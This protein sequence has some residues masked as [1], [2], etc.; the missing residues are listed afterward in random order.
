MVVAW[1]LRYRLLMLGIGAAFVLFGATQLSNLPV[2]TVPEFAPTYVEVQTEALGLSADEVEQLITVPL[3][4]DLL[5]GV[6]FLDE[7]HSQSVAGL[8]SIVMLFEPGTD[9]FRARQVVSERLTQAHAL[10]NVSKPPTMIQPLSS[11][12]RLMMI[13]LASKDVSMID[14]SVLAQWTVRPRLMSVPG[15]ANVTIWGMRDRQLQVVVDPAKLEKQG[16]TLEKVIETTGNSLWV[17]PLTFLDASTPGTGGFIDTP[18]QRLGVHHIFPVRTPADLASIV[19]RPDDTGG[20]VV[21]LG[22]LATVIE[23]HQPLIGDAVVGDGA[24]LMLV[25]E[26]FPAADTVEVT[27]NV[28]K[29]MAALAPGLTG[30]TIDTTIF[31]PATFIEEASSNVSL[32]LLAGLLLAAIALFIFLRGWRPAVIVLVSI[33]MTM[34]AAAVVLYV[35]GATANAMALAGVMIAALVVIDDTIVGVQAIDGRLRAPRQSDTGRSARSIVI[36]AVAEIRGSAAY[37]WLIVGLA[38]VPL[39]LLSGVAGSF[40]PPM[41]TAYVIASLVGIAVALTLTPALASLLLSK[42]QRPQRVIAVTRRLAG[43]YR[44]ALAAGLPRSRAIFAAAAVVT[45][46][47]VALAGLTVAGQRDGGFAPQFKERDL[48]IAVRAAPGTSA[49]EMHRIAARAGAELRALPGVANVGGHVGRAVASDQVVGTDSGAIWVS[50]DRTADYDATRSAIEDVIAGYSGLSLQLSTYTN[51]RIEAVLDSP[52]RDVVVRVYGQDQQVLRQKADEV[53]AAL[54]KV[55]GLTGVAVDSQI[56]EPTL[57]IEVDLAAA[58]RHGLKPGDVRRFTTTLLSGLEVGQIFEEQKV[59]QVV[60]WGAPELRESPGSIRNLPIQTAD[61]S[62]VPLSQVAKV[63]IASSPSAAKREG[64][65]RY[66]DVGATVS[67][68]DLRGVIADVEG[69]VAG[70]EFPFEYRAEV[71]GSALER[72]AIVYRLIAVAIGSLIG[73]LLLFQ[74]VFAS[75]RRAAG[76]L[77]TLPAALLGAFAGMWLLGGAL[78]IGVIAG[79]VVV[80]AFAARHGILIVDQYQR[81]ESQ[82]GAA[83]GTDLIIEGATDRLTPVLTSAAVIAL[84]VVPFII[85]GGV[86][87]LEILRPMAVVV[88]GGLITSAIFALFVI[89]VVIFGTGPSA[90]SESETQPQVEQPSLSPA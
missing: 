11:T 39:F 4:A 64:V 88:L 40:L 34:V 3:E 85:A 77:V 7:I 63:E 17:S 50:I 36:E 74:A 32:A 71:L 55:N 5:Q 90:E 15:V 12:S 27:G 13:S 56:D 67:G 72:E 78:S 57:Q 87:G 9:V 79:L 24:G 33:V 58:E 14:M 68:R 66:V 26:K 10:P 89:P 44:S 1:S 69:A 35:M 86:A 70:I 21:T 53:S 29:A 20:R 84:T 61:G 19:V 2:E 83:F 49:A 73:V 48:F 43:G 30:V 6:A 38:I 46:A 51:E 37:T 60:V 42:T 76:M 28:E 81:L 54:A 62:Y 80:L 52:Q 8:S 25:V 82:P 59:F 16:V 41:L 22:D 75:W 45:I 65:F 18:N 31:R 23:N 47:V